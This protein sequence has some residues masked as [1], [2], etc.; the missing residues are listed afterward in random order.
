MPPGL[1]HALIGAAIA[2]TAVSFAI[3]ALRH[4]QT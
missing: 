2:A 3:A 4:G 1:A